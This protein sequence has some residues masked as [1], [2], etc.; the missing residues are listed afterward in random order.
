VNNSI[1]ISIHGGR[2]KYD[3]DDED[4]VEEDTILMGEADE[5]VMRLL[6]IS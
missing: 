6:F 4:D 2:W 5:R 1:I 3:E